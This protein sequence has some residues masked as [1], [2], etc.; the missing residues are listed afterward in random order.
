[1]LFRSSLRRNLPATSI[2]DL[3]VHDRDLV[4]ATHGRSFWI[5]DD[6]T[7]LR[8]ARDIATVGSPYLCPP[9]TAVRVRDD[10]NTDTPFPPDEPV[11]E[12]PPDGA[13]LD[14]WLPHPSQGPVTLEILDE[15]GRVVRRFASTDA[16]DSLPEHLQVPRWWMRR[17]V[18][19]PTRV[20]MNRFVW[21]LHE[22]PLAVSE[23]S[24]PIAAT[25][26]RTPAEPRGPWAMPGRY[27]VRLTA[28][29]ITRERPL[30]VRMDP[31]VHV[32]TTGLTRQHALSRRLADAVQRDSA[33]IA[34][35]RDAIGSRTEDD[36]TATRLDRLSAL[37]NGP[38]GPR[39]PGA[40]RVANL[41]EVQQRLMRL[42]DLVQEAD[43]EPTPAMSE[44][45]S[46]VFADLDALERRIARLRD[47]SEAP[48]R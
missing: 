12:N 4:I 36:S 22:Q 8:A 23:R 41:E 34:E 38:R 33:L 28:S 32:T 30:T 25:P 7:P 48:G 46:R 44:A 18:A 37:L 40:A 42:Y 1:M 20:G 29:G 26:E 27:R 2:R 11:G 3:V 19:L 24:Y 39:V 13:L 14:Y 16:L 35:V 31:R 21:D 5:L 45:A 10:R 47:E 43:A 9:A 6:V 17:P 15:A